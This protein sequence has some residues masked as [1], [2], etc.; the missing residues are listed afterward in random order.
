MICGW[1]KKVG[2]QFV[3]DETLAAPVDMILKSDM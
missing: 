2:S 1:D 3:Y